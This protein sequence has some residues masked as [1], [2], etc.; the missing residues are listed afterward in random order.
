[1]NLNFNILHVYKFLSKM[2][3][4]E[5]LFGFD[6]SEITDASVGGTDSDAE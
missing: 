1:M 2:S 6:F 3:D 5:N 4:F